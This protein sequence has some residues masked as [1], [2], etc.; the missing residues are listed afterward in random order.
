MTHRVPSNA[1]LSA[2]APG[3]GTAAKALHSAA[4]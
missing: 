4:R 2:S 3:Q 1:G